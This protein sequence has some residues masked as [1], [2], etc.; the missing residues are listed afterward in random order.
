MPWWW[1][2]EWRTWPGTPTTGTTPPSFTPFSRSALKGSPHGNRQWWGQ[3]NYTL[4]VCWFLNFYQLLV[5]FKLRRQLSISADPFRNNRAEPNQ[6]NLIKLNHTKPLLHYTKTR[7]NSSI[8]VNTQ[9]GTNY[10]TKLS[11]IRITVHS[12]M[13]INLLWQP[14]LYFF[15]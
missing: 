1:S 9:K 11:N 13:T 4:M 7:L 6:T 8:L 5:H 2:I 14:L 10:Y 15:A 3:I 12:A